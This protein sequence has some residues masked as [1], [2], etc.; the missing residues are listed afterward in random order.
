[1]ISFFKCY[2][3]MF[4]QLIR[5]LISL[6]PWGAMRTK[7]IVK[8][9]IFRKTGEHFY[10]CP[11]KLPADPKLIEFGN[12]VAVATDV[13]FINHD[14]SQR[15]FN[16]MYGKTL[17][18]YYGCIKIG[19]NVFIGARATILPNVDICD[20]VFVAAGAL[21]SK[22]ITKPGIYGG[23]PAKFIGDMN[24]LYEKRLN[25]Y[26]PIVENVSEKDLVALLWDKHSSVTK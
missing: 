23:V 26:K 1:M 19:N 6:L 7:W 11:R 25:E 24:D 10:F 16:N 22:S 2:S 12:N 18:K 13:M 14:V 15:V 3:S 20:N 8:C 17:P 5:F 4:Y 9:H 21:V